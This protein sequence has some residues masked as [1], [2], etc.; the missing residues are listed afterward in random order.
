MTKQSLDINVEVAWDIGIT[1]P[2]L[3]IKKLD[4]IAIYNW[5]LKKGYDEYDDEFEYIEIPEHQKPIK[6][7][8]FKDDEELTNIKTFT[9]III[10][11]LSEWK[12]NTKNITIKF[13]DY[14]LSNELE[15]IFR[16]DNY[17]FGHDFKI[18]T[19]NEEYEWSFYIQMT[20]KKRID[21]K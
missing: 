13:D 20:N 21:S 5:K 19:N 17:H 2:G 16:R 9:D 15:N 7:K 8:I 14:Y 10:S 12:D 1:I 6:I 4:F 18:I 3:I 11:L